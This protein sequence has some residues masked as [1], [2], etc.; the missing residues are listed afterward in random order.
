M[1]SHLPSGIPN[2]LFDM[3]EAYGEL[4]IMLYITYVLF[5]SSVLIGYTANLLNADSEV[6]VTAMRDY[7]VKTPKFKDR[8]SQLL[9]DFY[10]ITDQSQITENFE[11]I[12]CFIIQSS[13]EN[14]DSQNI[15]NIHVQNLQLLANITLRGMQ[16]YN[17]SAVQ[18]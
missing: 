1:K 18:R 11:Q 10:G 14:I 8:C 12:Y 4:P 9:L 16:G 7:S 17:F 2:D 3:P 5:Y 6:W 13:T 15:N